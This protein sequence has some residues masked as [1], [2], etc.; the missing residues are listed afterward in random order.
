MQQKKKLSRKVISYVLAL[1]MVFSTFTGIVPGTS[2]TAQAEEEKAYAKYD[3]TTDSNST[4]SGDDLTA[5]QMTFNGRPW[6]II[7]DN[8]TGQNAGTVTLLAA[9]TSFGLAKNYTGGYL[10]TYSYSSSP[11]KEMLDNYTASGGA[12]EAVADAIE[13]NDDAD[14]KLYLLSKEEAE[15][16]PVNVRKLFFEGATSNEGAWWLRTK[17]SQ[18]AAAWCVKGNT[19]DLYGGY[20]AG[21][22][23]GVRPALKLDLSKV[24]FSAVKLTGGAN[25]TAAGGS[26]V[27]NYFDY[28]STRSAMTEVTFT[29]ADEYHFPVSSTYYKT[30]DGITVTRSSDTVV[31]VSGIPSGV[32]NITI[33]DAVPAHTHN[34]EYSSSGDTI[35]ATCSAEDC[36]LPASTVG[37]SDHVATLTIGAPRHTTYDDGKEAVAVITD[38]NSI[39]GD[40]TVKYYKAT[41]SGSSY[42]KGDLLTDAPTDVGDYWAEITLGTG[43]N[44]KTAG[45]G[46]TI[47]KAQ[48]AN[49]A[50][51]TDQLNIN[52]S[53]ETISAKDGYEVAAD[54]SGTT[55]TDFSAILDNSA[56]TV[57]I[58]KK[59][60]D[61]NHDHS[62]WVEV[63]LPARPAA[64][65]NLTTEN[66]TNGS[67]EDGK[68][69][70]TSEN[71]QYKLKDDSTDDWK[72]ASATETTVKAGTYLVRN[73]GSY[74]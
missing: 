30:T 9:D 24:T 18:S 31:T 48:E 35:T 68:I 27:Q 58:R 57:Y 43:D 54:N 16:V 21:S 51:N 66:A 44:A 52:Y 72:D 15:D 2:L 39:K 70:G 4:K 40:A 29:A 22:S 34:F 11:I 23:I 62:E 14:G 10:G 71:M 12:F 6:Y 50:A 38:E 61:T 13:K 32:A 26:T 63:S 28:G 49:P 5:L 17:G 47:E 74:S 65:T 3:V 60:T 53:A 67:S 7:K 46:Y 1:V 59:A 20:F 19:G 64:P 73:C 33:P 45:V 69:K 36:T 56:P 25:S 42:T 37:G 8:S 41:K 55:I